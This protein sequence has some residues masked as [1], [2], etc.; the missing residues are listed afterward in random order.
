MPVVTERNDLLIS[1]THWC[2]WLLDLPPWTRRWVLRR[3]VELFDLWAANL[4]T[5]DKIIE[6]AD[7]ELL[8]R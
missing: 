2:E 1:N 3:E 6:T 5:I 7:K 8:S 4:T